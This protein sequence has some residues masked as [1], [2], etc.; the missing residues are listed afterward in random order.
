MRTAALVLVGVVAATTAQAQGNMFA[1]MAMYATQAQQMAPMFN[2]QSP[3]RSF[4]TAKDQLMMMKS[5]N[6][7]MANLT[8]GESRPQPV[9]VEDASERMAEVP[10]VSPQAGS[11]Q[12]TTMVTIASSVPGATIYY[13]LDGTLPHWGSPQYT[14]PI[15]VSHSA[16]LL[17]FVVP[18]HGLRSPTVDVQYEIR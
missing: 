4:F 1:P 14:G 15:K 11:Y 7:S 2:M 8:T 16:H 17:T 6:E 5:D 13:S 18:P 9:K 3:T 12:G 10:T